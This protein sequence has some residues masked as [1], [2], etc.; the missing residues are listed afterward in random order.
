MSDWRAHPSTFLDSSEHRLGPRDRPEL[1][2]Q[3][4]PRPR[5]AVV[6]SRAAHA[7]YVKT[8]DRV[9][10]GAQARGWSLVSGGALGIDAG[11]HRAALRLGCPQ[12]AVLPCGRDRVYPG[13][14]VELFAAIHEQPHSGLIFAQP[15]GTEPCRAMFASRNRIVVGLADAVL[16][17]EASL[18]SGS[19]GTG[20][21]AQRAGLPL[22][23]FAGTPGCGTLIAEGALALPEPPSEPDD[24]AARLDAWLRGEPA[25]LASRWP[26]SLIWLRDALQAGPSGGTMIE[27]LGDPLAGMVALCEAELLGLVGEVG[28]GRWRVMVE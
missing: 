5:L 20:R 24:L 23:A 4:P 6:G 10:A 12:V 11:A 14:H 18:R 16:I 7:R 15:V 9:I 21:L 13:Q 1:V 27:Q 19:L 22:A 3:L 28:P 17:V 2:G 25:Q 8:L 26:E